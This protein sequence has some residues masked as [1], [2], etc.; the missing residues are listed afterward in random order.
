MTD[1]HERHPQELLSAFLDGE[2][3]VD[4]RAGVE[5]HLRVCAPCATLL[6]DLRRL[7]AETRRE[8]PPPVPADLAAR[9]GRRVEAIPGPAHRPAVVRP[10]WRAPLPLSAAATLLVG[11][12]ALIIWQASGLPDR[13]DRPASPLPAQSTA[14]PPSG[15]ES[16][17]SVGFQ[18]VADEIEVPDAGTP[19]THKVEVSY[20]QGDPREADKS[21]ALPATASD[22]AAPEMALKRKVVEKTGS[23]PR[24]VTAR[25][26]PAAEMKRANIAER[27][28][29][30]ADAPVRSP[31]PPPES[32]SARV[33][34]DDERGV[35]T[36][37]VGVTRP[38]IGAAAREMRP[39]DSADVA[40]G[41]AAMNEST[42]SIAYEPVEPSTAPVA[43]LSRLRTLE[44]TTRTYRA[45]LSETGALSLTAGSYTCSVT[46][47]AISQLRTVRDLSSDI[48]DEVRGLFA[49][50]TEQPG[51]RPAAPADGGD[52]AGAVAT[53]QAAP[54][55]GEA[56]RPTVLTLRDSRGATLYSAAPPDGWDSAPSGA[57]EV[58]AAG[59]E[60]LI[61]ERYRA[62]LE[63][64]CGP[65]PESFRSPE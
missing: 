50:A 22:E 47:P 2:L 8:L 42:A 25:Q 21:S 28:S 29:S 57:D 24:P 53:M 20:K 48:P 44:L 51:E 39:D 18:V 35:L 6:E 33:E 63:S 13:V 40:A 32:I 19:S 64:R 54:I 41:I 43:A 65:L 37:R 36:G 60:A 45:V 46:G 56:G 27:R 3:G 34:K 17:D 26:E 61:R 38:V 10:I 59:I 9:I 23:S 16:G 12:A 14:P 5:Q 62:H 52:R 11:V 31:A 30:P 1:Q 4:D 7:A 55:A 49:L 15:K 58:I